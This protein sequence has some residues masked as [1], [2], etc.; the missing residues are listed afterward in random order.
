MKK[1]RM[2]T[3]NETCNCR[4]T[5]GGDGSGF[6]DRSQKPPGWFCGGK[7]LSGFLVRRSSGGTV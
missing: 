1:R 4:K 6:R 3:E 7:W 5:V 2:K